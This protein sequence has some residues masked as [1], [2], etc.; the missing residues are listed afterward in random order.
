M[1]RT[2]QQKKIATMKASS[3]IVG[4]IQRVVKM[5]IPYKNS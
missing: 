4:V 3:R 2:D 5:T 1:K